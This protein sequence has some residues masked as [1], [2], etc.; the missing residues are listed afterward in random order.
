MDW[1][2]SIS[3]RNVYISE[4]YSIQVFTYSESFTG[5][6]R[7]L[8]LYCPLSNVAICWINRTVY[9]MKRERSSSD[10]TCVQRSGMETNYHTSLYRI[11]T[12]VEQLLAQVWVSLQNSHVSCKT[13]WRATRVSELAWER[14]TAWHCTMCIGK[15][16]RTI[17][18]KPYWRARTWPMSRQWE[19]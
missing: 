11:C 12:Q 5:P 15:C 17:N 14:Q 8:D 7:S 9:C 4:M 10:R 18:D 1:I 13:C 16:L 3:K 6:L 2:S 19:R